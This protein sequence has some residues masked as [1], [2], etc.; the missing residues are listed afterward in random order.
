MKK[1]LACILVIAAM[2]SI[3]GCGASAAPEQ[4]VQPTAET[5]AAVQLPEEAP[6]E[7]QPTPQ[8]TTVETEPAFLEDPMFLKVSSITFSLVGESDDIYLGLLPRELITWESDDPAVVSVENGVLTATGVG[9]TT[10]RATYGDRQLTC[11]AGCLAQTQE[12][13]KALDR[14]ILIQ[15]RCLIPEVDM[16]GPCTYFENCAIVGDSISYML[17]QSESKGDYLGNILFLAR[18]GTSLNG[19]VHRFKNLYYQG[20]EMYLEDAVAQSGV[21]RIYI[22]VGSNDIGSADQ[23]PAYM[24][25]WNIVLERI[26]EKSPDVE[27]VIIS[28]IPLGTSGQG[29]V[30]LYNRLAVEYNE[31]MRLLAQEKGCMY[32][33]LYRYISDHRGMIPESYDLDG[34]HLNDTGYQVWMQVMR[35]YAKFE[36]S[37]GTLS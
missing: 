22:L 36:Q 30:A 34:Y 5:S 3:C 37:G 27:V 24:D 6:S 25:N 9:T 13:L 7:P 21:G 8:E 35:Y 31:K 4:T 2:F 12:D 26:W 23:R 18:G 11:T 32:L 28:N 17:M 10:I 14:S 20:A 19:F 29:D 15:P 1:I 33:D 16:E